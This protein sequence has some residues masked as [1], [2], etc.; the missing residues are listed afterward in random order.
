MADMAFRVIKII[1]GR[2]KAMLQPLVSFVVPVLNGEQHIERC[3]L[4]IMRQGCP[5]A[6]FEILVLD[7]GSI[8]QTPNIVK[9]VGLDC[10]VIPKLTVSALRNRGVEKARG[11][12]IAFVD[13]DVELNQGWLQEA[14]SVFTNL[15]IVAAGCMPAVPSDATWVQKTWDLHQRV[16]PSKRNS[17]TVQWLSSMNLMVR[18]DAFLSVAG[19]NES[20]KTSEDVD[21]SYRL[22]RIGRIVLCPGMEAIHWGEAR[23]VTTFWRKEVWRGLGSFKGVLS[24]G[25]RVDELPSLGYPL[26]ILALFL[27]LAFGSVIDG[28]RGQLFLAPL[29]AS[30]L[31]LPAILLSLSTARITKCPGAVIGLFVLYLVYGFARAVSLVKASRLSLS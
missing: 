9:R 19:F 2:Y 27:V 17:E 16:R 10:I 21:L 6:E 4:S 14:R 5:G 31:V 3:L 11:A 15:Q 1:D 30:I 13:S 8:D 29:A 12:L 23:D 24:H 22:S 28:Y 18:R 26:Y 20:L 25:L 7:N